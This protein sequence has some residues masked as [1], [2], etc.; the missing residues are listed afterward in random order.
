MDT[1][2]TTKI[3]RASK[4]ISTSFEAELVHGNKNYA[5]F[6]GNISKNGVYAIIS[7]PVNST[8]FP[9][10]AELKLKIKSLPGEVLTLACRQRWTHTL[11][12]HHTTRMMGME[13]IHSPK[14]YIE[15]LKTFQ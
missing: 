13:I 10:D 11:P 14:Q 2:N 6:I 1:I 15:F 3:K 8:D 9:H 4:R 12:H 5:A 7:H